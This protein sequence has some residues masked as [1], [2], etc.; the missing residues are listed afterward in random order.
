MAQVQGLQIFNRDGTLMFDLTNR[1]PRYLGEVDVYPSSLTSD[2]DVE[3][4]VD[5]NISSSSRIPSFIYITKVYAS[6]IDLNNNVCYV[7]PFANGISNGKLLCAYH[8]AASNQINLPVH[9]LYG[10]Y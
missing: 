3:V 8:T 7:V 2:C 9:I 6:N 5:P 4:P 10:C 1:T